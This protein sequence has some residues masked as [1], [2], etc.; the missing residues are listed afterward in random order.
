MTFPRFFSKPQKC[1][2]FVNTYICMYVRVT[3]NTQIRLELCI[4]IV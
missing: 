1:T 3:M 4:F 2:E